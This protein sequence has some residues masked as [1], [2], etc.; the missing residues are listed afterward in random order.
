M[1]DAAEDRVAAVGADVVEDGLGGFDV[2]VDFGGGMPFE[3]DAGEE[4]EDGVG[5]GAA[6]G[7]DE[8][9]AVAVAVEGEADLRV[10][11]RDEA[12][13]FAEVFRFRRVH[14]L[15]TLRGVEVDRGDVRAQ[16][17]ERGG[18]GS[19]GDCAAR[20]KGDPEG[21]LQCVLVRK[22]RDVAGERIPFAELA[23]VSQGWRV[24][25]TFSDFGDL[26]GQ[27][28]ERVGADQFDSVLVER[29]V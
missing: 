10:R 19:G 15:R 5:V 13:E 8:A 17:G 22:R 25:G 12:F 1:A 28:G 11:L 3:V 2:E 14:G 9:E 20:V 23:R 6:V 29:V 18:R 27:E 24:G 21:G 26:V 4:G 16:G 7:E